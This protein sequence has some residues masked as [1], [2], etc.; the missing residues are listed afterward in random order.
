[1]SFKFD[2]PDIVIIN[3]SSTYSTSLES[4]EKATVESGIKDVESVEKATVEH[5]T[6]DVESASEA[7][8]EPDTTN[9]EIHVTQNIESLDYTVKETDTTKQGKR[10][11]IALFEKSRSFNKTA[12]LSQDA[13]SSEYFYGTTPSVVAKSIFKSMCK[14]LSKNASYILTIKE[15]DGKEYK[16]T[17]IKNGNDIDVKVCK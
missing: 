14:C 11:F 17:C 2:Y 9:Q 15:T 5:G 3:P 10:E 16:Y 1:M 13:F 12:A 6:K 4:V 8:V 7:T